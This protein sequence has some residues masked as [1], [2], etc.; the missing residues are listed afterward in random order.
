MT[1]I[2][3]MEMIETAKLGIGVETLEVSGVTT[4]LTCHIPMSGWWFQT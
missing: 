3:H 4:T 1:F 2:D